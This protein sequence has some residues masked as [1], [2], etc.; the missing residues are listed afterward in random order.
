MCCGTV[1]EKYSEHILASRR[2]QLSLEL[3]HLLDSASICGIAFLSL[4]Q[5]VTSQQPYSVN[6]LLSLFSPLCVL[7]DFLS[8]TLNDNKLGRPQSLTAEK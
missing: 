3:W 2:L 7:L 5:Q 1:L 4:P 6:T 8:L